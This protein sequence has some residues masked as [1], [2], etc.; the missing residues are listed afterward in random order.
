MKKFYY[1]KDT[2]SIL[3]SE[4]EINNN[5]LEELVANTKEA[6]LEKHIPVV[7]ELDNETEI[8]VGNAL[9]PSTEEH[10][11]EW[12]YVELKN[13]NLQITFHCDEQPI[14]IIPYKKEYILAVYIYFNLHGLLKLEDLS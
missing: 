10:Y 6:A 1:D 3:V 13:G 4:K 2:N 7:K 14:A 11:I 12:I 9:H 8:Q 5:Q